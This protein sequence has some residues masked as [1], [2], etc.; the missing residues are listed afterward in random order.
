MGKF[1]CRD[2]PTPSI[3]SCRTSMNFF[4][5]NDI[6][7][8]DHQNIHGLYSTQKLAKRGVYPLGGSF[9]PENGLLCLSGPIDSIAKVLP[10]VHEKITKRSSV[11]STRKL[12]KRVV[13]P[14]RG[15]FDIEN[16]PVCQSGPIGSMANVLMDQNKGFTHFGDPLTLTMGWFTYRDKPTP[17]LRHRKSGSAKDPWTIAHENRQNKVFTHYGDR[18]T[19]KM[20]SPKYPWIIAL[21]NWK[22]GWFTSFGAHFTLKMGRFAHQDQP[23]P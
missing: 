16:G 23:T 1:S 7:K 19:L 22:N 9:D 17:Y 6:V 12:A 3:M 11:Y 15:S 8:L 21:E 13:Y 14:F 4:S 2:Q 5:K 18:S 10:D 20:G